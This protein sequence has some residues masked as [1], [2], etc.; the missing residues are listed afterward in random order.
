MDVHFSLRTGTF[1]GALCSML[2]N[3]L[4]EDIIRTAVLA[5]VGTSVSFLATLFLKWI[6]R[7][8]KD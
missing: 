8:H 7:R 3:I 2:P 4:S 6:T 5:V 1:S